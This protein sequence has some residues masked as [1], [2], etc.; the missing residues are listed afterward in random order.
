MDLFFF[1]EMMQQLLWQNMWV[2][3]LKDLRKK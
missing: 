3:V 2:V 1:L